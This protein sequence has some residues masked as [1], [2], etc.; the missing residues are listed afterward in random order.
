VKCTQKW[1]KRCVAMWCSPCHLDHCERKDLRSSGFLNWIFY[2]LIGSFSFHFSFHLIFFILLFWLKK[3]CSSGGS[4]FLFA[5]NLCKI[6]IWNMTFLF[7]KAKS[8]NFT[9]IQ[10]QKPLIFN[11]MDTAWIIFIILYKTTWKQLTCTWT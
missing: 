1:N 6:I 7:L 4:V 5:R 9:R 2:I 3:C 8:K 11:D 10:W